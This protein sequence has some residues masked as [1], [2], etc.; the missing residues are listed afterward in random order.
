MLAPDTVL[1]PD[2]RALLV[3]RSDGFAVLGAENRVLV[4]RDGESDAAWKLPRAAWSPDSRHSPSGV[5][6]FG[7]CTRYRCELLI[8]PGAG[9]NPEPRRYYDDDVRR[10]FAD[11]L[12]PPGSAD[13]AVP[14]LAEADRN[15]QIRGRAG[16]VG[17]RHQPVSGRKLGMLTPLSSGYSPQTSFKWVSTLRAPQA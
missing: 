12:G 8:M 14:L 1:A 16:P 15:L 6:T 2:R 4:E 7:P 9:H 17:P 3:R 13:G 10:Y 5:T 11:K